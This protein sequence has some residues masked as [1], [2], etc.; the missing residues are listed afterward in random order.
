MDVLSRRLVFQ[1]LCAPSRVTLRRVF[2]IIGEII[3]SNFDNSKI[4]IG[5]QFCSC[6]NSLQI[7]IR[8]NVIL[9][10]LSCLNTLFYLCDSDS[11]KKLKFTLIN[12]KSI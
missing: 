5:Q 11:H 12:I 7:E 8:L 2:N 10:H 1:P 9:N 4:S 6:E 3:Q